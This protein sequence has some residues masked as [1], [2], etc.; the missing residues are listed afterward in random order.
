[1]KLDRLK[2]D[3]FSLQFILVAYF[4]FLFVI[5]VRFK[6]IRRIEWA[7]C[8]ESFFITSSNIKVEELAKR[9]FG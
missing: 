8:L 7:I 2:I 9:C 5:L 6:N 3:Y 4:I 1:M